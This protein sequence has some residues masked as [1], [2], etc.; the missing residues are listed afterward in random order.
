M[1][2]SMSFV[3]SSYF[4]SLWTFWTHLIPLLLYNKIK[5]PFEGGT[6][7]LNIL[8]LIFCTVQLELQ[9]I[10][11]LSYLLTLKGY[12]QKLDYIMF[13]QHNFFW[14]FRWPSGRN[15]WYSGFPVQLIHF[16]M[17]CCFFFI[18]ASLFVDGLISIWKWIWM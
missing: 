4:L 12:F 1:Y 13:M 7:H 9:F 14:K 15:S 10:P 17:F 16:Q 6:S 11:S 2:H 8:Q 5:G 3:W 18:N